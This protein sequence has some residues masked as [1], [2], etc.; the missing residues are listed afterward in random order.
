M[1]KPTLEIT[2]KLYWPGHQDTSPIQA[3]FSWQGHSYQA[4][5]AES[6]VS[7]S[8]FDRHV[9]GQSHVIWID[10]QPYCSPHPQSTIDFNRYLP[11]CPKRAIAAIL[12]NLR[13]HR[14]AGLSSEPHHII[15]T[16]LIQNQALFTQAPQLWQIG[17][18]RDKTWLELQ[19]IVTDTSMAALVKS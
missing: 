13:G 19:S 14:P 7:L 18:K 10:G 1:T 11:E 2:A 3:E 16:Q 4:H 17:P 6:V 9:T 8:G 15:I 5:L 12:I